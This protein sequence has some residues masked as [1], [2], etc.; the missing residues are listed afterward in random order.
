MLSLLALGSSLAWGTS[1]FLAGLASRRRHPVAV[2]GWTQGLA[3]V[4]LTVLV[5]RWPGEGL[6]WLPWAVGAGLSGLA[7]LVCFYTALATGTMGV[8]APIAGLGVVVPVVLGVLG[9]ERP[10]ALAWGG[11]VLAVA[12]VSLASGPELAAGLSVRP[13][14]L[15][16]GAA[17]GFGLTLYLIDRG[18]RESTLMTLWGMR[19]TSVAVLALLSLVLRTAGGVGAREVPGLFVIGAGDL[20]ANALFAL[21]SSRGQVSLA[22]VLG[23]LYPVVTVLLARAVLQERLRRVQQAGVALAAVG[24]VLVAA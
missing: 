3:L 23:S 19:V 11:M 17:L 16:A 6:G 13:V 18:A 9:G 2:V 21:A 4:V 8:V 20:G 24:A 22:S 12:G 14:A 5:L 7:G 10:S 15:A 1:D